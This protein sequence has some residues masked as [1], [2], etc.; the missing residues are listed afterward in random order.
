VRSL[1][2]GTEECQDEAR[3]WKERS[4]ELENEVNT[5][6]AQLEEGRVGPQEK[7]DMELRKSLLRS[8]DELE[9][10]RAAEKEANERLA[11]LRLE[12]SV[13]EQ[14]I[15]ASKSEINFLSRAMEEFRMNEES[16]RASL[17]YRI[18]SLEDENDVLRRYHSSELET[19][20]NELAQVSM[21]KDRILHQLKE[22]EK[23]NS[24][25]VFAAAKAESSQGGI[26]DS[27]TDSDAEVSKLRIENAYL[28]TIAADD[29]AR[30]E[31]RLRESLAAHWATVEAD[32]FLEHELRLVA[33]NRVQSL[34]AQ[35]EE[36]LNAARV[37]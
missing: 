26:E 33:E 2:G 30:A 35:L 14:E 9:T 31:R 8:V 25:L 29:K 6:R 23:T 17:D 12:I 34:Q 3:H 1:R 11:K 32:T 15:I 20:R 36:Y 27:T 7:S 28:L 24:A 22:S 21:E 18:G 16:K 5:L 19:V 10:A 13:G 4:E 37:R